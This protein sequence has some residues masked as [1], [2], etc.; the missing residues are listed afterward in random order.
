LAVTSARRMD[1]PALRNVPTMQELGFKDLEVTQWWALVA[2]ATTPLDVIETLRTQAVAALADP[3][4]VERLT[5]LGVDL[6][7]ATRDQTRA[8]MRSEAQRWQAVAREIGL[9]PQ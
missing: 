5:T 2:P 1:T 8:F 9:M 3:K 4:V 7:G 6:Q